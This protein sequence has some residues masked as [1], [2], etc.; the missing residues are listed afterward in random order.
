MKQAKAP[1]AL[2]ARCSMTRDEWRRT[3]V[4]AMNAPSPIIE[5]ADR[6]KDLEVLRFLLQMPNER[7]IPEDL[8]NVFLG[9]TREVAYLITARMHT[10]QPRLIDSWLPREELEQGIFPSSPVFTGL[11]RSS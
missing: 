2:K 11:H 1:A 8:V 10:S 5:A 6:I 3:Q 7:L 4:L 9:V